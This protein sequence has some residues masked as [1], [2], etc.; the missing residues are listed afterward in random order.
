MPTQLSLLERKQHI[1]DEFDA[2]ARGYDRLCAWNPG[3]RR[4]LLK[5]AERLELTQPRT[6]LDLCCGTGLSTLALR[7]CYPSAN[8]LAIDSSASMLA[9]A[10]RKAALSGVHWIIGDASDPARLGVVAPVD[11][12]LMAYGLRNLPQPDLCLSRLHDLLRPGGRLCVHEYSVADSARARWIW[13]LVSTCIVIPAGR[14]VTGSDELFRYLRSSVLA[15]D[16]VAAIEER[17]RAAGFAQVRSLPMDGWQRGVVHSFV[18]D[19]AT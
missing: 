6:L 15:F 8:I 17:L 7:R 9:E 10:R 2:V 5:S 4:H 3:Y 1:G 12:I 13:R 11:G 14:W 16:G 19:K 18:A